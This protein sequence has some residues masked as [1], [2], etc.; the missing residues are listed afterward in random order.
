M[1][2]DISLAYIIETRVWW[3]ISV[4]PL[5]ALI[6]LCSFYRFWAQLVLC[7]PGDEGQATKETQDSAAKE[8]ETEADGT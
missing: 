4:H 7:P 1:S 5:V 2:D 8:K 6:W 3:V